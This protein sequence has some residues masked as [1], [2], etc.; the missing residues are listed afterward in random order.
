MQQVIKYKCGDCGKLFDTD[1]E[2]LRH[3]DLHR[4]VDDANKMLEEGFTLH[5]INDETAIWRNVPDHLR[6]VTKHNC[7]VISHWQ[8]CDKPA[9]QICSIEFD[10]YNCKLRVWGCGSWNGYYGDSVNINSQ[11]LADPR[12]REEFFVDT[13]YAKR[14]REGW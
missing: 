5:E 3:E 14:L 7:F 10:D 11:Y 12:P 8:C 9:Y 4:R 6:N 13:Q 2:C 1:D